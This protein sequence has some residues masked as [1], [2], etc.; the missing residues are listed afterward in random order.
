MILGTKLILGCVVLGSLHHCIAGLVSFI[1]TER[2]IW[3]TN[4]V[5][6]ITSFYVLKKD[7]SSQ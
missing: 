4:C 1:S 3:T 7:M 6:D 5:S 2:N